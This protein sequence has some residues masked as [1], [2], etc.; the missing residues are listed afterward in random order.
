MLDKL[1]ETLTT[2]E[3]LLGVICALLAVRIVFV[4]ELFPSEAD[5]IIGTAI[6]ALT[7][8]HIFET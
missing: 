4:G 6:V 7:L 2:R 3:L 5:L 8:C 1:A